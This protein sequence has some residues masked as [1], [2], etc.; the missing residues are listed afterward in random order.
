MSDSKRMME[1]HYE[2]GNRRSLGNS[3]HIKCANPDPEMTGDQ[4][5]IKNEWFD[6]PNCF[7]PVWKTKLCANLTAPTKC[8]EEV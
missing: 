1:E 3:A 8:K 6:Y 7:D 5:G 4:H 2:C